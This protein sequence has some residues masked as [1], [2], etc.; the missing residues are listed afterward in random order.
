MKKKIAVILPACLLLAAVAFAAGGSAE[1]PLISLSHLTGT[2][3]KDLERAI[4]RNL[5]VSDEELLES[6]GDGTLNV[7]S[8][9]TWQEKRL[10]QGDKL[11]ASTGTNVML[12]AGSMRVEY[13]AGA[14]VDATTG[15]EVASGS[16]LTA[17]HRYLVAEETAAVFEVSSKTAVTDYQGVC[18]FQYSNTV[19]YNAMAA[20]LKS[21]NLFKGSFTGYGQGFDLE[22][23]PTRLQALIMFIRVLGEEEQALSWTGTTPFRDLAKGSQAEQYVGY[24]Y[25]K[26]YTNGYSA[27]EFKPGNPVNAYQYTEFVL[28][29][30]GYSSSANTNLAD[31]LMRAEEAGVLNAAEC[32]LL[33]TGKFLRAD[34]VY[35]SYYALE[36]NL[37]NSSDMLGDALI[38][39]GVFSEWDWRNAQNMVPSHRI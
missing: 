29:A 32:V 30:M 21:M 13:V 17:K 24:A 25:E 19:D 39:K 6:M 3:Q 8:T 27:T 18:E 37:P 28:R 31:T 22:A 2:F 14:V 4:D 35:I 34:L 5:D 16:K 1:D 23:A 15:R 11:L 9:E 10:K 36:A 38:A 20:A 7:S 33:Q 26:G 12:L